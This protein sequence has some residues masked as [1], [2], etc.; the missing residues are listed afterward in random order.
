M[1]V[2]AGS[3]LMILGALAI[4]TAVASSREHLSNNAAMERECE[5]YGLNYLQVVAAQSG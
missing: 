2:L 5:R 4:S 1:L 3:A